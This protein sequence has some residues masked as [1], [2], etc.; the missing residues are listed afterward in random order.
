MTDWND[1][2]EVLGV[3]SQDAS[4]IVNASKSL[5]Q[6]L[7]FLYE[8]IARNEAVFD[9]LINTCV[10]CDEP[11]EVMDAEAFRAEINQAWQQRH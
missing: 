1:R 11:G 6:D 8:A 5:R 2:A 7:T 4:L 10:D 9:V 3:V